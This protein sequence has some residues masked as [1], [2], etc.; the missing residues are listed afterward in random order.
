MEKKTILITGATS[1]IGKA[2]AEILAQQKQ[3]LILCGRRSERLSALKNNLATEVH[4]LQ[5]DVC[6]RKAVFEA[7]D[8]LPESWKT[9]DVL[10]NNAGNAHGLD[11]VHTADLDD[12]EAMID[13][14]V[15]GLMYVTKAILPQMTT[16][17]S[18]QIINLGSI[19]GLEVYA[20][21][22]VYCA[23][24]Y[25]VDA[26]TQGLR[27]DLNPFGIRVGAIHPGLVE[28]EFSLVR[29]K[30]DQTRSDNVYSTL[31][32]L[33]AEDVAHAIIYMINAPAHVTVADLT[34]LPTD[35]ANATIVNRKK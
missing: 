21:G 8:T 2:T 25:A 18:G 3:R 4:T 12:W 26:F 13:G 19:A 6:D 16:R 15:K 35:Q 1:G 17:K 23:S 29:F 28:T 24:K 33:Q 32:A 11:P 10:V 20:N 31:D 30:G 34:L 7:I 22:N 27:I 9:I 5:F 14:N